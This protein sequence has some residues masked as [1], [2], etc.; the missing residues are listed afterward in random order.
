MK[1]R[2]ASSGSLVLSFFIAKDNAASVVGLPDGNY[3][4][5]YAF[6]GDLGSD[7]R[8]FARTT[9]A[10]QFPGIE[11][12]DTQFT[13]TEIVRSHLSLTLYSV[14]SGNVRPESLDLAAFD[15]A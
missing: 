14:P 3:R 13:S 5:Q 7:C 1:I 8:S 10:A 11:T 12:F 2:N 15:A 4:M 9:S 6:G